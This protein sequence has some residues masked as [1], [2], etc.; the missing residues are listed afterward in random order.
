MS[1]LG[2]ELQQI[3]APLHGPLGV[4]D[5]DVECEL[6]EVEVAVRPWRMGSR[7]IFAATA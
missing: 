6:G 7:G 4:V 5:R 1:E 2:D 3:T